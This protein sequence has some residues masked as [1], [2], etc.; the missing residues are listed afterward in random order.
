[1]MIKKGFDEGDNKKNLGN[2]YQKIKEYVPDELKYIQRIGKYFT[3]SQ[4]GQDIAV[5]KLMK[6]LRGG[7]YLEIGAYEPY[8]YSNTAILEKF[9][10]WKGLSVEIDKKRAKKFSLSRSNQCKEADALK[11]DYIE[12]LSG[13]DSIDYLSIDIEPNSLNMQIL[14][15]L[16]ELPKRFKFITFEHNENRNG[17][18]KEPIVVE[19]RALM[20]DHGYELIGKSICLNNLSTEDWYIDKSAKEFMDLEYI[21]RLKKHEYMEYKE[22][23]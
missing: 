18:I 20:S 22:I 9:Y 12:I 1:M 13:V 2:N 14:K 5:R 10:N 8:Q 11:L 21:N 19:S 23:I 3:Y 16:I 6:G 17:G 7:Y 4:I 15:I